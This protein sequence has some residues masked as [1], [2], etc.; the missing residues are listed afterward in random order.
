MLPHA[1][2]PSTRLPRRFPTAL[3]CVVVCA[4]VL[5]GCSRNSTP[6]VED[7][8]AQISGASADGIVVWGR[9]FEEE[10]AHVL[11]EDGVG[12]A[13]KSGVTSDGTALAIAGLVGADNIAPPTGSGTAVFTGSTQAVAIY[14]DAFGSLLNTVRTAGFVRDDGFRRAHR[15]APVTIQAN[16]DDGTFQGENGDASG[17]KFTHRFSGTFT[18]GRI[19]GSG[20]INTGQLVSLDSRLEG[21]I[22]DDKAVLVF[23]ASS[24]LSA[25]AGGMA[26]TRQ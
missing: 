21:R 9:L 2:A 7:V 24:T 19:T 4:G 1:F 20:K 6:T 18:D 10:N 3:A 15:S 16:L 11:D 17:G 5:A 25:V 8:A 12:Y 26:L 14:D 22:G 23:E 13:Y